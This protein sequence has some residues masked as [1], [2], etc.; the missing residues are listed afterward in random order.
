MPVWGIW[1]DG[2]YY[3]STSGT[4]RKARNLEQNP[5]CVVCTEKAEE[6][7]ILEGVAR[8]MSVAEVPAQAFADYKAK[9][10]WELDPKMGNIYRVQPQTYSPC[11]RR[12][13][14]KVSPSGFSQSSQWASL[15]RFVPNR[16]GC[17]PL[18]G[19]LRNELSPLPSGDEQRVEAT[20]GPGPVV[21][22]LDDLPQRRFNGAHAC[23]IC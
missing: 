1:L 16:P 19:K 3:F 11:R 8:V 22:L 6:V 10:G 18:P 7:I 13:S 2:A 4:S 20:G 15:N 9:Y 12:I 5:N 17:N 23:Q 14:L 21:L